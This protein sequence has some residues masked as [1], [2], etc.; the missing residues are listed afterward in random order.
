MHW[1]L[2]RPLL[3]VALS[4]AAGIVLADS[5]QVG[6]APLLVCSFIL[7]LLCLFQWSGRWLM[8]GLLLITIGATNF[9]LHTAIISPNDLRLLIGDRIEDA[10]LRGTLSARPSP[11]TSE[12]N[13]AVSWRTVAQLEV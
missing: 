13:G 11:R 2:K 10:A 5:L 1:S 4:Y 6:L 3:M 7:T 12:Q 8:L 9:R